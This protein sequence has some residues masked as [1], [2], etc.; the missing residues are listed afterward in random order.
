M[1]QEM[2]CYF[3]SSWSQRQ[4]WRGL[5]VLAVTILS[6][7]ALMKAFDIGTYTGVFGFTTM[8]FIPM[9]VVLGMWW[10]PFK[11]FDFGPIAVPF[12][13]ILLL[14]LAGIVGIL[15]GQAMISFV[16]KG[17]LLPHVTLELVC[18]VITVFFIA[19][20]FQFWPFNRLSPVAGGF[21][22][23]VVAYFIGWLVANELFNFRY[24]SY[25][26]GIK[27]SPVPPVPFYAQGGS[28]EAFK[29]LSPS[30]PF[31]WEHGIAFY[32]WSLSVIFCFLLLNYW[33]FT[34]FRLRQPLFGLVV[35]VCA[36]ILSY[37]INY[38]GINLLNCEP[39]RFFLYGVSLIFGSLLILVPMETWP[40]RALGKIGGLLNLII[41]IAVTILAYKVLFSICHANFGEGMKYP[42]DVFALATLMLGSIFPM[43]AAYA[44]LLEFWPLPPR[45]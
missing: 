13:G 16:G 6:S 45:K 3:T 14:A 23:L 35:I 18:T 5:F 21:L 19:L 22:T 20:A 12:R 36:F 17:V 10:N 34:I 2:K 41:A 30:G 7:L 37:V 28:L 15:A 26:A 33:P 4:P 29:E 44:D 25:P 31:R 32:L 43:W 42:N 8:C 39:L 9:F 24:L 11:V 40:G 38:V 1:E 27:P